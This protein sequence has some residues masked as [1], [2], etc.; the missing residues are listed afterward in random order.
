VRASARSGLL[1]AIRETAVV[2]VIALGLSLVVKTFL[3]Q[4]FFIPSPSMEDT[5]RIGDRVVVSKLTPGPF[6]LRRGDVVVFTDPGSW[7][8][9]I[10]IPE[11]DSGPLRSTLRFVG[12]MP[13]DSSDHLI[14]R[15]IGLPG[16]RIKCCAPDGRITVNGVPLSEPYLFPGNPPSDQ[17]FD[18]TVPPGRI[19]VMGDHRNESAD[20]RAHD[21]GTGKTGSVPIGDVTG[22]A[23]ALVWPISH[24]SWLSRHEATF[25]PVDQPAP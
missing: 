23:F 7:L 14:K 10:R 18:I 16:D 12:L 17:P 22:R 11:G 5:L 25:A 1:A 8:E 6:A 9:P 20:S 2:V 24:A 21:D 15:L 13:N 19:W 3:F 4:A